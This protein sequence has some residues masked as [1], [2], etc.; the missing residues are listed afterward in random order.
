MDNK[1]LRGLMKGA[2]RLIYPPQ[3]IGCDAPVAEEGALCPTCWAAAEFIA[4]LCCTRCAAPL[5]GGGP[6]EHEDIGLLVCDDCL[7]VSRPWNRGRAAL[8]YRGTGR[9]LALMLKHGDRLDL[10]PPLGDWVARAAGPLVRRDMLVMPVPLHLRR[11]AKR[12]YNQAAL[13]SQRVAQVH[14]LEHLPHALRRLRHTPMQDHGTFAQRFANLHDAIAVHRRVAGR[15]QGRAVLL[16]DD[17]MASG[18][19]LA[20]AATALRDAGSGPVSVVVLAR[21]V[22][23]T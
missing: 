15:I 9:K 14:G 5:P 16:V 22:K 21:A 13:L 4:G 8:V 6:E 20:A 19:T 18:A 7:R 12:K 1:G 11:L 2:L 23:D 3:C 17:V 10:A